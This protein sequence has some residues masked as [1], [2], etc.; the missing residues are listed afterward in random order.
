MKAIIIENERYIPNDL[1]MFLKQNPNLFESVKELTY[2]RHRPEV[3]SEAFKEQVDAVIVVSSTFV[4]KDQLE[5]AVELLSHFN[6]QF[7]L[8]D[9]VNT[10]NDLTKTFLGKPENAYA[11]KNYPLVL[12]RIKNWVK[13]GKVHTIIQNLGSGQQPD[14]WITEKVL[15]SEKHKL[16]YTE[17]KNEDDFAN[18]H[19]NIHRN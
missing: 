9:A 3:I 6:T 17:R 11:F 2:A 16:F 13:D 8:V 5:N 12:E 14:P 1:E 10:L 19:K 15:F 7:Y 4:H 18:R